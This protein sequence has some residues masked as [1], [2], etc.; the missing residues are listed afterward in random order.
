[1]YRVGQDL[2]GGGRSTRVLSLRVK[3]EMGWMMVTVRVG[4]L[5]T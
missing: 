1:M 4:S 5:R 3:W 2:S